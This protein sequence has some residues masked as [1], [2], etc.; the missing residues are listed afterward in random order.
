LKLRVTVDTNVPIVANGRPDRSIGSRA[1]SIECRLKAVEFLQDL[2]KRGLLVLDLAGEI[3]AEYQF[4]LN[5]SGQPGVGDRFYLSVL[6]SH[7]DRVERVP[8][9]KTEAGEFVDF[10]ASGELSHFDRNDRKF[11]ALARRE[12]IKVANATDSDWF[13][14]RDA[15]SAERIEVHFVCGCDPAQWFHDQ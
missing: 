4:H 1:P 3:Q 13:H 6:H 15:L 9:P 5:P 2:H 8:L 7:P 12:R 11:A 14:Y 10:P